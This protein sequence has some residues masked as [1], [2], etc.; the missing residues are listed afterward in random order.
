[1]VHKDAHNDKER[2]IGE[3]VAN[4]TLVIRIVGLARPWSCMR[5][6]IEMTVLV[7]ERMHVTPLRYA[8]RISSGHHGRPS[9]TPIA[10]KYIQKA[11]ATEKQV[12]CRSSMSGCD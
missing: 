6:L 2:R 1:M 4:S 10:W 7:C 3:M 9:S 5:E 8:V 11:Y 12:A